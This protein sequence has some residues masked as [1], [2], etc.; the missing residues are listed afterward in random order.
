MCA[1]TTVLPTNLNPRLFRSFGSLVFTISYLLKNN[2]SMVGNKQKLLI[3]R[4]LVGVTS[5]LFFFMS[6]QY[7]PLGSA[8][9]LRY[10]APFFA[11]LFAWLILKERI[12]S[13]QWVFFLI[14]FVGVL[15]MKGFNSQIDI[16]GLICI[17]ISAI[18]SGLVYVL[19][20]KIETNDHPV[21]VVHYYMIMATLVG[22][23][24]SIANWRT[25]QNFEWVLLL[26]LGFFGYIGQVYM[27]KAFQGAQTN[28]IAQLK[29]LEVIFTMLVGIVWF[30]DLYNF[31][32]LLGILLIVTG[33]I[34]N[35]K[36]KN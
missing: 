32:S 1:Y 12:K 17:L 11:A 10:L 20:R 36:S 4:G 29:Y 2:I 6:I 14:A 3:L 5:M 23:V 21:V 7:L 34:L 15:V 25:P 33:L 8:V 24:L 13:I 28:I 18:F 26:S 16:T 31:W 27:T 19:I 22:G 30:E 9:S 35:M